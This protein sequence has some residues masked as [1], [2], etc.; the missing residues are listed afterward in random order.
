MDLE[1][2]LQTGLAVPDANLDETLWQKRLQTWFASV[3]AETYPQASGYA[4]SLRL[5]DDAEIQQLNREYRHKD[6]PTDVLA[7]AAMEVDA[8]TFL[9]EL[10]LELGDIV[11]S[12]ETARQ[13]AQ[14]QGHSLDTELTWLAAHGFLHL[15]GW[16]HPDDERLAEML[17]RQA[18]LLEQVGL[19]V[20][21]A[22][23][24]G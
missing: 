4:L 20:N 10:P 7:F 1:V 14:Q 23:L 6:Q 2:S 24:T 18:A 13:Q 16:D 3:P 22:T 21:P 19:T 17:Q 15:L 11:I 5:T 8:P 12:V 9:G